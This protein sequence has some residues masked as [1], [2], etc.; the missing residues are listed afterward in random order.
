MDNFTPISALVG[1]SL[2]GLGTLLL[3]VTLGR[4]AGISGIAS[5]ALFQRDG[6]SW[7]LAFVAG[8]LLGP[9][10][11]GLAISDFSFSTPDLNS[12]T[13]IAGLLVG[14]GTAW[15][16]GCTSGHGICGIGRFSPRSIAATMMFMAT[17]VVVASFF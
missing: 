15:G 9:L 12:R 7:R 16:S 4:I 10:L 8:L 3:L 13:L 11:V 14:L 2:I 17:G 6:R 1:G 5:Q